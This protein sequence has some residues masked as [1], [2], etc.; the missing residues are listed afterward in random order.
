MTTR[1][2]LL[3]SALL[4]AGSLLAGQATAAPATGLL[5]TT[6]APDAADC[7]GSD[8]V[9]AMVNDGL[10]RV[11]LT[12]TAG[13]AGEGAPVR[14]V[15][16][17]ERA[18]KGYAATVSIGGA[19]G[20]TRHLSDGGP[21]CGPLA[22][23]VGVL[24]VVLLDSSAETLAGGPGTANAATTTTTRATTADVGVGGGVA[25]GLVGGLSPTLGLGGTVAYRRWSARLGGVW[26]PA[27]ANTYGPGRVEVGL[28]AA[29]LALCGSIYGGRSGWALGLCAQ[30]QI[31]ALSGRGVDYDESNRSANHLWLATGASIVAGGPLGRA[32]GWEVEAAALHPWQQERF[33]ITNLGTAFQSDA[34]AFMTT[35]ALTARVW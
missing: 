26:L 5:E 16:R 28:T 3:L 20:G 23:A 12:T 25:A 33:V 1:R 10:G 34:L 17:F 30:Q 4:V 14:V 24:L 8:T 9:A 2:P 29:R 19:R 13:V 7:P 11:G 32:V 27:K 35:F 6:K 15:V 18:P 31:G 22:S 21:G